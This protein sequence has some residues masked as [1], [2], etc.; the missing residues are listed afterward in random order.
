LPG[1]AV[2]PVAVA[3]AHDGVSVKTVRRHYELVTISPRRLGV[4]VAFLRDKTRFPRSG[5]PGRRRSS[6]RRLMQ[7]MESTNPA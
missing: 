3:A 6:S 2:V 4:T 1:T 7:A 5:R